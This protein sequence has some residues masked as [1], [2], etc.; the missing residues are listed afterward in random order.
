MGKALFTLVLLFASAALACPV[1][2]QPTDQNQGAYI[3]MTVFLSLT[4]LAAIGG[5]V[6]WVFW[7]VRNHERALEAPQREPERMPASSVQQS[8]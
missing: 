3:A 7:R 8:A 2:G 1:C 4:P 5:I 6:F